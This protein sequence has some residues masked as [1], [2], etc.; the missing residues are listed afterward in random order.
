MT[1]RGWQK[2]SNACM[3]EK[4]VKHQRTACTQNKSE[5]VNCKKKKIKACRKYRDMR[6]TTICGILAE[7][8]RR[9]MLKMSTFFEWF[10]RMV[11]NLS[12]HEGKYLQ[13]SLEYKGLQLEVM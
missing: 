7:R 3:C 8:G 2:N 4:L 9:R 10:C 5:K 1:G 6:K 13:T 11:V 12:K